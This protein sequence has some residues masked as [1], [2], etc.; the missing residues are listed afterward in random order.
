MGIRPLDAARPRNVP[1]PNTRDR[2]PARA[3]LRSHTLAS[4]TFGPLGPHSRLIIQ[5]DNF[6]SERITCA[7]RGNLARQ[8]LKNRQIKRNLPHF[9]ALGATLMLR[10]FPRQPSDARDVMPQCPC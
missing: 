7:H 5:R 6:G 8:S 9:K 2:E 4:V 1:R 10:A 3:L